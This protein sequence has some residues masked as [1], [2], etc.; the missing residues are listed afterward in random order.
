MIFKNIGIL[1]LWTKLALALKGLSMRSDR[2]ETRHTS[3]DSATQCQVN[4]NP[5]LIKQ[6]I[7]KRRLAVAHGARGSL[8]SGTI[9]LQYG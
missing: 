6:K 4:L 2:G 7:M 9:L 1:V 5:G 3:I 8:S